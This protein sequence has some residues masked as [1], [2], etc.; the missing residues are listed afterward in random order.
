MLVDFGEAFGQFKMT[1]E[2]RVLRR[3]F[4][5]CGIAEDLVHFA[6]EG[7]VHAVVVVSV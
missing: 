7:Y 3:K 1:V 6:A 2:K 4:D 5:P